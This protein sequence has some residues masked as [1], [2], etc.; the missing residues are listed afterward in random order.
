[1]WLIIYGIL[2]ICFLELVFSAFTL[3]LK[4]DD[5]NEITGNRPVDGIFIYIN[6]FIGLILW[7]WPLTYVYWLRDYIRAVSQYHDNS[8]DSDDY[9]YY[10]TKDY[11][12]KMLEEDGMPR[13]ILRE[14]KDTSSLLLEQ[15]NNQDKMIIRSDL[16]DQE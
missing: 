14:P 10:D 3:G 11:G 12:S 8:S 1:M 15:E 6:Y 13:F 5:C 2:V 16:L 4:H 9:E 7:T